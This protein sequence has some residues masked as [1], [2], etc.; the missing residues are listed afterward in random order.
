MSQKFGRECGSG[1]KYDSG[2]KQ[3]SRRGNHIYFSKGLHDT[4]DGGAEETNDEK[5]TI[6]QRYSFFPAISKLAI[7]LER[8]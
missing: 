3:I 1:E 7:H 8:L 6:L 4:R 2:E 5:M